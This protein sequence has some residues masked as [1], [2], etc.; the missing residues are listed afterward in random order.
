MIEHG[1]EPRTASLIPSVSVCSRARAARWHVATLES[2]LTLVH[3]TGTPFNLE[4]GLWLEEGEKC[5][6]VT[7]TDQDETHHH[8]RQQVSAHIILPFR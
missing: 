4:A 2:T 3:L 7:P 1:P 5:L 6:S 8:C